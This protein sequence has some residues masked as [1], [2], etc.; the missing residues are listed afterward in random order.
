MCSVVSLIKR[1]AVIAATAKNVDPEFANF[2]TG[3]FDL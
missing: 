2:I 1:H 3:L